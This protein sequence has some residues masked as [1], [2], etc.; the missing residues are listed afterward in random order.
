MVA[1]RS[2]LDACADEAALGRCANGFDV[3]LINLYWKLFHRALV[4]R[5]VARVTGRCRGLPDLETLLEHSTVCNCAYDGLRA[6][7]ISQI[8]GTEN[9][10]ADFDC[11]LLP[12]KDH[13]SYR[14]LR[15]AQARRDGIALPPV[16]LIQV[17]EVYY[18]RDGHHRISVAR[19]LGEQAIDAEITCLQVEP[20]IMHVDEGAT[21]APSRQAGQASAQARTGL[22]VPVGAI[23]RPLALYKPVKG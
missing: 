5:L 10:Y 14:W 21:I 7:W 20:R 22:G 6:V 9:R 12:A 2:L 17:G 15:V 16:E 8:R 18:I 3:A 11:D 1:E 13:L 4:A 23:R 19:A